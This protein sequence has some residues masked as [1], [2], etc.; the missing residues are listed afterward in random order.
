M[1]NQLASLAILAFVAIASMGA[2]SATSQVNEALGSTI[3]S[4]YP[5]GRTAEL[6]LASDGSYT[7]EGR[8]HDPSSGHWKVNGEK[9]CLRQSRPFPVWFNYCVPIPRS[10]MGTSWTGKAYTGEAIRIRLV[11]GHVT[12]EELAGGGR[13]PAAAS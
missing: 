10:G 9:L 5:D 11:K 2:A 13:S 12:G 3:V 6:W 8:R 1:R 7:A 4:T